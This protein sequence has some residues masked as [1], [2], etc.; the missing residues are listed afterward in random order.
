MRIRKNGYVERYLKKK[1]LSAESFKNFTGDMP[2]LGSSGSNTAPSAYVL[3]IKN[4]NDFDI[5]N[6]SLFGAN[7]TV[8]QSA[9]FIFNHNL[10]EHLYSANGI[11][12]SG[13]VGVDNYYQV[14]LAQSQTQPFNVGTTVLTALDNDNQTQINISLTTTD[15]NG[16]S[17]SEPATLLK[18]PFQGQ[19]DM[20][21]FEQPYKID[22]NT[23]LTINKVYANTS[24][25]M[26]FYT[27]S[28]VNPTSS[29]SGIS[30]I[31]NYNNP[32]LIKAM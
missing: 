29:L 27:N 31:T 28:N 8:Y 3:I 11:V 10:N 14:L 9:N 20:V 32:Q 30:T 12:I 21:V 19:M 25:A 15:A 5:E 2:L 17:N 4:T 18:D 16:L 13:G 1:L 6:L 7:V 26:Y 24:F 23:S 22:G